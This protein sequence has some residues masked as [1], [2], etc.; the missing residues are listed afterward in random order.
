[1]G[2]EIERKFLVANNDWEQSVVRSARMTQG[3][4][5]RGAERSVR[6]RTT[7]GGKA[8][9]NIKSSTT[10]ITRL[11]YEYEIPSDDAQEILSHIALKPVI[12]KTRHYIETG[13]HTWEVDVFTGE[14][15]GLII[16]EIELSSED[17]VFDKPGWL[18]EEVSGDARYYNMN[19]ID[20]PYQNWSES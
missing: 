3:Y 9:L 11:E 19:L 13:P 18:G 14:N 20:N 17:E 6:V 5:G 16:A 12:D 1:M 2:K 4:L 7:G 10:G 15:E 8:F